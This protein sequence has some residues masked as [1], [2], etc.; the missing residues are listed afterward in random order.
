MPHWSLN[1]PSYRAKIWN[2]ITRRF[3]LD[4]NRN[5]VSINRQVQRFII[6]NENSLA[7]I[8]CSKQK[9]FK[10]D[11]QTLVAED[12]YC[13]SLFNKS[14]DWAKN[15]DMRFAILSAKY[16]LT[17]RNRAIKDY[18]LTLN[19][20][21]A[22]KRKQW[23]NGVLND[24]KTDGLPEKVFLLAGSNYSSELKPL[25]ENEGIEVIQPLMG[26]QIGERLSY[27][28]TDNKWFDWYES[29]QRRNS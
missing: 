11:Q 15:R 12:A 24:L 27:L 26:M 10:D 20:L 9:S 21:N 19:E 29:H 25:L 1:S 16:G 18:D 6:Q 5:R 22:E 23:A 7:L 3:I 14:A 8:S 13:S 2:P 28:T 17:N 4:N